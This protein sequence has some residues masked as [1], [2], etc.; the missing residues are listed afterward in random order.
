MKI[1]TC[2][3]LGLLLLLASQTIAQNLIAV[4][5]GNAPKFFTDLTD[6]ITNAQSK[7][8]IYIPGY[9]FS[10][11]S[12]NSG[13]FLDKELH[14][15]GVGYHPDSTLS[16]G[17]TQING[18]IF[19]GNGTSYG[20]IEGI[21]HNGVIYFSE[22]GNP[23][24]VTSFCIKRNNLNSIAF[25]SDNTIHYTKNSITENVIRGSIS[26]SDPGVQNNL[27]SNNIIVGQIMGLGYNN[28]IKNNIFIGNYSSIDNLNGCLL[29]NNIFQKTGPN[30]FGINNCTFKSNLSPTSMFVGF[31]AG[32]NYLGTNV[33][34]SNIIESFDEIF[35][36]Y[37][38]TTSEFN[39]GFDFHIKPTSLGK[40][41]GRDGTDI[42]I[43]GGAF[44]WKEG[45]IPANP[46]F[47]RINISPKT[48]N[49]GNLN[50]KIKVAAQDN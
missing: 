16:T 8:T 14:F 13:F 39:Y 21:Y 20:S 35:V 34:T 10:V 26:G 30:V 36:N 37:P 50:V 24:M 11:P 12:G 9:V 49:C 28:Q 1:F 4:Q 33:F 41:A 40:N 25:V 31:N 38:V 48:D 18:N 32:F 19:L 5:N 17:F 43:Y 42:G 44:P 23:S 15:I 6:A 47:Q 3:I 46:H 45:S 29:E 22:K 27:I 7:D 2:T